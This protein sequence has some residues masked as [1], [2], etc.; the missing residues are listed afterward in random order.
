MQHTVQIAPASPHVVAVH[1]LPQIKREVF[2]TDMVKLADDRAFQNRPKTLDCIGVD[3][4]EKVVLD[5]GPRM[6]DAA[7]SDEIV[8]CVV[9]RIFVRR[10]RGSARLHHRQRQGVHVVGGHLEFI[11]D[12]GLDAPVA[13]NSPDNWR[14]AGS[15]PARFGVI[16][17]LAVSPARF[18]ADVSFVHFH[19][20]GE[21]LAVIGKRGANPVHHAPDRRAAHFEVAGGLH[22]RQPFFRIEHQRNKKEPSLQID[23]RVVKDGPDRRR[24]AAFTRP[25]LKPVGLAALGLSRD[26]ISPALGAGRAIRPSHMF[27][28][29]DGGSLIGETTIDFNEAGHGSS[30]T[31]ISLGEFIFPAKHDFS[32]A[33][34]LTSVKAIKRVS[35]ARGEDDDKL[36]VH[37]A[38]GNKVARGPVKG[39]K[40][41]AAS[42]QGIV[43]CNGINDVLES[44][45]FRAVR[46]IVHDRFP[47]NRQQ[48]FDQAGGL[49]DRQRTRTVADEILV[50][51]SA[52]GVPDHQGG[53]IIDLGSG[54]RAVFS[55][56]T[57]ALKEFGGDF[58]F[59]SSLGEGVKG[60]FRSPPLKA[61][62][63][64]Q[65]L[66]PKPSISGCQALK[67]TIPHFYCSA[68]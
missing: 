51:R 47:S 12:F 65:R 36:R 28:M 2:S 63:R 7:M 21:K 40:R 17:I 29:R 9:A 6:V 48:L 19:K 30:P 43:R 60:H 32:I 42:A 10:D 64:G 61:P 27:Q 31:A 62:R 25:A 66:K 68:N 4:S 24:K 22:C 37:H 16:V 45:G 52:R 56:A 35:R 3:R 14:L 46:M 44:G 41:V 49:L 18:P 5:I 1:D 57:C 53:E 13:F 23:M 34:P 15:S 8:Q 39:L 67:R 50:N 58:G 54:S 11:D 38:A 20:A 26:R 33:R 59:R 55:D